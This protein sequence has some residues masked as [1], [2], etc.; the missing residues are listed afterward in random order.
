MPS[1]SMLMSKSM[2]ISPGGCGVFVALQ[3]RCQGLDEDFDGHVAFFLV[4]GCGLGRGLA[5][6]LVPCRHAAGFR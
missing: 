6:S 5:S 1:P 4:V 2:C 3:D